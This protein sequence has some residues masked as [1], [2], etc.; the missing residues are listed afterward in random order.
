MTSSIKSREEE[1][2][3]QQKNLHQ[4]S[5]LANLGYWIWTVETDK[6]RFS[7]EATMVLQ[8]NNKELT[9]EEFAEKMHPEDKKLF[10][11]SFF[12]SINNNIPYDFNFRVVNPDNSFSYFFSQAESVVDTEKNVI[13]MIGVIQNITGSKNE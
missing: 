10:L 4:A 9:P 1:L 12:E 5:R 11:T 13:S 7:S 8:I 3:T 6:I 2:V